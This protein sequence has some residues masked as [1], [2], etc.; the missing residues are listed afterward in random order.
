MTIET[1]PLTKRAFT[2]DEFCEIYN[3]GRT[4]FYEILNEGIG[5][6]T[7]RVGKR[8][9]IP[10]VEAEKWLANLPDREQGGA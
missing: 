7:K 1:K 5:P 4:R 6:K 10:V 9:L 2:V 3:V 8:L